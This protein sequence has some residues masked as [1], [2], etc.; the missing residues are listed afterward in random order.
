[1]L[2][3]TSNVRSTWYNLIYRV[4]TSETDR[5]YRKLDTKVRV[6]IQIR[7]QWDL[8]PRPLA[9]QSGN[10]TTTLRSPDLI[11]FFYFLYSVLIYINKIFI[12][13]KLTFIKYILNITNIFAN[14]KYTIYCNN[15]FVNILLHLNV[16]IIFKFMIIFDK[17]QDIRMFEYCFF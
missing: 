7:R 17:F 15:I 1:M 12:N 10:L 4:T 9:W 2:R 3:H 13:L 16:L 11:I 8:N 6:I 14:N 5:V